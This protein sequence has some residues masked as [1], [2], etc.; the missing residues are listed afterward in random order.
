MKFMKKRGQLTAFVLVG[1]VILIAIVLLTVLYMSLARV[2][3]S[4]KQ[5]V[6]DKIEEV[7]AYVKDCLENS[8]FKRLKFIFT[9][10]I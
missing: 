9:N 8:L 1:F 4:N 7:N 6:N 5:F 10:I 3:V 2:S